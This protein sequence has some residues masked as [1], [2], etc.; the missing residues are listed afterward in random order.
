MGPGLREP[1]GGRTPAIRRWI[2]GM[3]GRALPADNPGHTSLRDGFL[4]MD[5]AETDSTPGSD[6][7]P[8]ERCDPGTV[9]QQHQAF[10]ANPL[11]LVML[12]SMLGPAIVLNAQRQIV[13]ANRQFLEAVGAGAAD[14]VLTRRPGEVLDCVHA[15]ERSGGCGTSEHCS[16]CGAVEAILSAW[17]THA[18]TTTE[19]RIRTHAGACEGALDF[20]AKASFLCVDGTDF[21]VLALQD[22]SSEKRRRV[23]ERVFFHD[24][25][26]VCGGVHGLAELLLTDGLDAGTQQEFKQDV[27]R[28]SGAVIDEITGHRQMLAAERGELNVDLGDVS[29]RDVLDEVVAIYRHHHVAEGRELARGSCDPLWLRTDSTLLRRVLGNLIKN[30]LEATPPG[31]TVLVSARGEPDQVRISVQNPGVMPGRARLQMFQRSFS[32]KGGEGRGVGTYSVKLFGERYLGGRVE[33]TSDEAAGTC[34][35]VTLPRAG[36]PQA[37]AA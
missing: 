14:T 7:A 33:F 11:A 31:G 27:Y 2:L 4:A 10:A 16:A 34:F 35:T 21:V 19:C 15:A 8:A 36:P 29:I 23:L 3:A 5:E 25:L 26:N 1:R 30:A 12:D 18:G 32:T 13:V 6:F 37:L 22:I 17:K 20:R 24:V 9:W 28:L